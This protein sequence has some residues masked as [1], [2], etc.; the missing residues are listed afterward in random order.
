MAISKYGALE[1]LSLRGRFAF[2]SFAEICWESKKQVILYLPVTK[3]IADRYSSYILP[4]RKIFCELTFVK[5]G[6]KLIVEGTILPSQGLNVCIE[7][8]GLQ[9]DILVAELNDMESGRFQRFIN[10]GRTQVLER[11][12]RTRSRTQPIARPKR[13]NNRLLKKFKLEYLVS[14]P[15]MNLAKDGQHYTVLDTIVL[16][17][18]SKDI[19]QTGVFIKSEFLPPLQTMI[20]VRMFADNGAVVESA[21]KVVRRIDDP[22]NSGFALELMSNEIQKDQIPRS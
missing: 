19:S 11:M 13:R 17:G 15:K 2:N 5:E 8:E 18:E 9:Q 21:G 3:E 12:T 1:E 14:V 22:P 16:Q 10:D 4:Y 20:K 7:E 6:K